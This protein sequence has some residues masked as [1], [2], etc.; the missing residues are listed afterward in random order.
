M[1]VLDVIEILLVLVHFSL[2]YIW[3]KKMWNKIIRLVLTSV[4][5]IINIFQIFMQIQ[6]QESYTLSIVLAIG[7]FICVLFALGES[8]FKVKKWGVNYPKKEIHSLL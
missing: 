7:W 6:M 4:L 8:V 3:R 5:T 1:V 2:M